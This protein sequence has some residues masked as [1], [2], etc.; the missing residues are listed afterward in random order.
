MPAHFDVEVDK[1]DLYAM[2]V[3]TR[4]VRHNIEEFA[5][6]DGRKFYLLAEGRLVNLGASDGHPAEIMDM[7]F[8]LQAMG[9]RYV[10]E[11]YEQLG[12]TGRERAERAR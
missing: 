6:A 2:A 3:S 8:A 1:P 5:L 11:H 10:N 7:T 4:V 12:K 9:L